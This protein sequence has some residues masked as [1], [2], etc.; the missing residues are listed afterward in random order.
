MNRRWRGEGGAEPLRGFEPL[1]ALNRLKTLNKVWLKRFMNFS[2][3][4]SLSASVVP[5]LDHEL[6]VI[7]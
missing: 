1:I 3:S 2:D 5:V 7:V 6:L 4:I